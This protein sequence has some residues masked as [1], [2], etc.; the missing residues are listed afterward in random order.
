MPSIRN[1]TNRGSGS[2]ARF[3]E[4]YMRNILSLETLGRRP[5]SS[6]LYNNKKIQKSQWTP[7]EGLKTKLTKD[8]F[9]P[10]PSKRS[11]ELAPKTR[12]AFKFR[13][14]QNN[15]LL[16]LELLDKES[17]QTHRLSRSLR[18]SFEND[19]TS[20]QSQSRYSDGTIV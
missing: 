18:V 6:D 19:E 12:L 3:F 5:P 7:K 20:H 13:S 8:V 16:L 14:T 11:E 15:D 10:L 2:V 9:T 1:E 17:V 4:E